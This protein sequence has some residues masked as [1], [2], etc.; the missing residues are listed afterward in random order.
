VFLGPYPLSTPLLFSPL[1]HK[2]YITPLEI[3]VFWDLGQFVEF[4]TAFTATG[5]LLLSELFIYFIYNK[6]IHQVLD[7]VN[8]EGFASAPVPEFYHRCE[9]GRNG[10]CYE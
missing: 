9:Q 1:K 6:S 4:L 8:Q 10:G 3:V 5:I 2:Q 7:I